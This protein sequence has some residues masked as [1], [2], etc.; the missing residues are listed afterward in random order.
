MGR[1]INI[2]YYFTRKR[3]QKDARRNTEADK[4]IESKVQQ[5]IEVKDINLNKSINAVWKD[6]VKKKQ[7]YTVFALKIINFL[8]LK[9]QQENQ[10]WIQMP[11]VPQRYE[12]YTQS[13][14][15]FQTEKF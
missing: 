7:R 11:V 3:H 4:E 12:Q 14:S 6:N 10:I 15:S 2:D 9:S 8:G 1:Q 13:P 5:K